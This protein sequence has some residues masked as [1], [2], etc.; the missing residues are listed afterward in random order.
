MC[1]VCLVCLLRASHRVPEALAAHPGPP[2]ATTA[3]IVPT[4]TPAATYT[5]YPT[6]TAAPSATTQPSATTPPTGP[7]SGTAPLTGTGMGGGPSF[8]LGFL[9]TIHWFDFLGRWAVGSSAGCSP[10]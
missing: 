3:T 5:P 6:Y 10:A 4:Q 7:I 8:S 9:G 1:L 2:Q